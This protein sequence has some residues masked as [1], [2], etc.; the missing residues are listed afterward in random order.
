MAE[1]AADPGLPEVIGITHSVNPGEVK[2]YLDHAGADIKAYEF[3]LPSFVQITGSGNT[4]Q[5]V[6]LK[7]GRKARTWLGDLPSIA[8]LRRTVNGASN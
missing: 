3:S 4:P 5:F 1:I 8:E 6:F 2:A 7:R